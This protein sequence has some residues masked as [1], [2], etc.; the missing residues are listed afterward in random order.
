MSASEQKSLCGPFQRM[1]G[2]PAAFH[3]TLTDV[4]ATGFHGQILWGFLF[5]ALVLWSGEPSMGQGPLTPQCGS[6]QLRPPFPI[7]NHLH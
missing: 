3:L 1:L 2:F 5:L 6:L 4:I 7:L